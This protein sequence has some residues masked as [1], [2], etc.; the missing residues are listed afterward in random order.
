MVVRSANTSTDMHSKLNKYVFVLAGQCSMG[1]GGGGA[2]G[3][4]RS[5]LRSMVTGVY[6]QR[7]ALPGYP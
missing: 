2:A 6:G 4:M 5:F 1:E 3:F 7:I